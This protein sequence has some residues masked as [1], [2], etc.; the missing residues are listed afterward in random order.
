MGGH[1]SIGAQMDINEWPE[2]WADADAESDN[3]ETP[4]AEDMGS[5]L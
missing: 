3:W 5:T 1:S 2:H 4:N